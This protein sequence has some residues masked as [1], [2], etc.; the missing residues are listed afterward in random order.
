MLPLLKCIYILSERSG[1]FTVV[2]VS[3]SKMI[4]R[5]NALFFTTFTCNA[6]IFMVTGERLVLFDSDRL[7]ET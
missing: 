3:L 5:V 2:T 4:E 6:A 7:R 1:Y